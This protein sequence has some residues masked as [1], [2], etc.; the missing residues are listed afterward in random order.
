MP[1]RCP[2]LQVAACSEPGRLEVDCHVYEENLFFEVWD[3]FVD[4]HEN[5]LAVVER[6]RNIARP[7][8]AVRRERVVI[9]HERERKK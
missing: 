1:K 6:L 3:E 5:A 2:S 7:R 9:E 8:K 4:V